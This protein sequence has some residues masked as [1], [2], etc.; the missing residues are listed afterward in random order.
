VLGHREP[1]H[2][3]LHPG[4]DLVEGALDATGRFVVDE[5][6]IGEDAAIERPVLRVDGMRVT[7]QEIV[8]LQT[9][10]QGLQ[11]HDDSPLDRPLAGRTLDAQALRD[12]R[13]AQLPDEA[14]V[15]TA[16]AVDIGDLV[17]ITL[18]HGKAT[19]RV[20]GKE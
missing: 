17:R 13:A 5:R 1:G 19:C 18:A 11:V 10:S 7:R 3:G 15:K 2:G 6:V 9:V 16:D 4:N 8:D 12:H 14:I 20:E